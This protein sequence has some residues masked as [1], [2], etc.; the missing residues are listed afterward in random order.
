M[1]SWVRGL[2]FNF[3]DSKQIEV[4]LQSVSKNYSTFTNLYSIGKS[5]QGRELWV[6]VLGKYPMEHKVG[7]PEF[8]YVGNMHGDEVVGREML[9]HLIDYLVKNYGADSTVTRLIDS[10]RLHVLPSMNP[11]GFEASAPPDCVFSKGSELVDGVSRSP[12]HDVFVHLAKTYSYNH[13]T[14]HTGTQCGS[15][16]FPD[17]ITNGYQWY[18]LIGG[19]QD[20]NYV[21]GQCFEITLELSCCKYPPADQLADFWQEN[22]AALL[23]YMQQVHLGVKGQVLD[24]DGNPIPSA[25]V[26]VQGRNN[27]CPY[28]TN[29]HG[30]YYRLLLPGMYTFVVTVPGREPMK[31]TLQIPNGPESFSALKYDF[32]FQSNS[33]T[34][35]SVATDSCTTAN[36]SSNNA[37]ASLQAPHF[38]I[39]LALAGAAAMS[40]LVHS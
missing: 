6:L 2:D 3:H 38:A 12:D 23:A 11:D 18:T 4:Y 17:G 5:V 31:K 27:I 40:G 21:W 22:R 16:T 28:K 13:T 14:M 7:I 25:V 35:D 1:T 26:E 19:M 30:E 9:L 20:Y 32:V 10:S 37:A 34:S 39:L 33:P 36:H 29:K 15:L 24:V 8:K